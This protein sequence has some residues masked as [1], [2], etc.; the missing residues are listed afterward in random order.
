MSVIHFLSLDLAAA[1]HLGGERERER[2][3]REREGES[4]SY[5]VSSHT[6]GFTDLEVF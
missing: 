4:S 6:L 3:R 1:E 5:I 2:K